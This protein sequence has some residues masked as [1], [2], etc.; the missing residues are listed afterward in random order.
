[1]DDNG[2]Y[3]T[4]CTWLGGEYGYGCR[5]FFNGELVV[6]G[7]CPTRDLIG[8]TFRD[9]LRTIDKCGGGDEFTHAARMRNGKNGNRCVGVKHI[10]G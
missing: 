4:K 5:I 9:L 6:E 7:R 1:M 2:V 10:W 8:A 3:A